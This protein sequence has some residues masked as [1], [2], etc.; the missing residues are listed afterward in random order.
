VNILKTI[1]VE[2]LA[3]VPD[4]FTG[5]A[6]KEDGSR[7]WFKNGK[8][9]REDGPAYERADEIKEWWIKGKRHREDGPAIECNGKAEF[10]FGKTYPSGY[11]FKRG[12]R[13]YFL[14]DQIYSVDE[15]F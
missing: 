15:Y 5:I 2:Y 9:H 12:R 10:I 14:N 6:E 13:L 4:N 3:E 11:V 7:G 8:F 1:K